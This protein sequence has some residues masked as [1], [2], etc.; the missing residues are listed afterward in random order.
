MS[1]FVMHLAAEAGADVLVREDS[2]H[3]AYRTTGGSFSTTIPLAPGS[4]AGERLIACIGFSA[5]VGLAMDELGFP[6]GWSFVAQA[7]GGYRSRGAMYSKE[8]TS[9][10][11]AAGEVAVTVTVTQD[12]IASFK[13][14]QVMHISPTAA[15]KAETLTGGNKTSLP[16]LELTG[17]ASGSLLVAFIVSRQRSTFAITDARSFIQLGDI[18]PQ[19]ND[20]TYLTDH[21]ILYVGYRIAPSAGAYTSPSSSIATADSMND[22]HV[23]FLGAA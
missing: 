18:L 23:E 10:D 13:S 1:P 14:F 3:D 16:G 4:V 7:D 21:P 9:A 5:D 11:V 22:A 19:P 17:V 8:V 6:A 15:Q 12:R 20:D 2:V